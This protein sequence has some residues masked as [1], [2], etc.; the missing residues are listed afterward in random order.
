[1]KIL[2]TG[3]HGMLG[4][5][6]GLVFGQ[7]TKEK[8]LLTD[9]EPDTFFKN[10][11]FEYEQLDVTRRSDV[12]SL[13]SQYQPDVI[14]N[15][16]A[17]TDVDGCETDREFAWRLNVD[18]LKNLLIAARKLPNAYV[19]HLSTDFIFDGHDAPYAEDARPQPLSYYGKSKLAS[20]NALHSSGVPCAIVRTQLLYG[21]G[22]QVRKNFVTWV[23]SM[24]EAKQQFPV[25]T[26]Q[27]G[28]P[29][30]ADDLAFGILKIIERRRQGT[31]HLAGPQAISRYEWAKT[32]ASVFRF[33][34][35][36]I[37][38]TV[39]AEIGQL[40]HRPPNS[41]F[42]TLKFEAEFGMR[43]A[44]VEQGLRRMAAQIRSGMNHTDLLP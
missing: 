13:L 35:V 32:V 14:I 5:K 24:L 31:Y 43:F 9:L 42:I 44:D 34:P 2:I 1:M 26:D 4:Q 21:N 15:T 30:F 20:E 41:T 18:G 3:A 11:R 22:Y 29:T 38:P 40:A 8:L 25:V 7:E 10:D 17:Y 12:K 19:V 6:L 33:D 37:L 39:S 16:A 36:L 27:I 28:N 23:L